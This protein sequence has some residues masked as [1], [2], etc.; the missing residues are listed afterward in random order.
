V[1]A[2]REEAEG[3]AQA[4]EAA[5]PELSCFIEEEWG[6]GFYLFVISD[7]GPCP[8]LSDVVPAGWIVLPW[9]NPD[10]RAEITTVAKGK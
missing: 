8:D 6:R 9:G 3:I 4:I 10:H 7:R 2:S 1:G 5:F